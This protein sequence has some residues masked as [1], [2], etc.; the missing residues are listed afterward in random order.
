MELG[1]INLVVKDLDVALRTYL[2]LFGTNN[3]S[4]VIKLKGLSDTVDTIDGYY[5]RTAPVNLGIFTP[6]HDTGRM[7]KHLKKS[8]EGI[9][10]ITMHLDQDEFEHTYNRFKDE[11]LAVSK[12][13][14]IGKFSESIFWLEESEEQGLPIQFA[15][16]AY[17]GLSIWE[18]TNYLDTPQKF[19]KVNI[20]EEYLMPRVTLGTIMVTVKDWEKQQQLWAN[21]LS[22]Q[23]LDVGN[24]S[25]L[26]KG[27]VDDRRGNIFLPVKFRFQAGGAI[28]LYCALNENAPINKVLARRGQNAMYHNICSYV[29]RDKVH[30]YWQRLED[31]GFNMVDPKPLLNTESGNGNYFYFVHPLSTHGVLFEIVSAYTMD[32]SNKVCYDWCDVETYMVSPEINLPVLQE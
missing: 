16:K 11:G 26:E 12:P 27:K 2:K 23:A 8:G 22:Q 3:V 19:E 24:L 31:A 25:T 18:E 9:H 4:Q 17:H 28:N 29:T 14:Y 30:E 20:T 1:S 21:I 6:R 32:E 15:T 7:G 5:L 10:H 13:V